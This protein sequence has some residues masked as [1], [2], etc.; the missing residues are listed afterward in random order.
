MDSNL[1]VVYVPV[2]ELN[3]SEYNPRK[4][5][6]S[7]T[8]ALRESISRFGLVDPIICN[9]A[10]ERKN[11]VIGGHFRLKVAKD[12]KLK[13]VPVVYV[14]IADIERE[15]ELNV[16]LNKNLGEFD[17]ELLKGFGEDFLVDVGFTSEEMDDIFAIEPTPEHFDLKAELHKLKIDK[18]EAQKGDIYEIDG[19]RLMVG[20]STI[21]A[22]MLKLMNGAQTDFCFTDPPYI[23]DLSLIH[24]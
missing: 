4:W 1:K 9:S 12:L 6:E 16:R 23:L 11:I 18:I 14:N 19:S 24:I 2:T 10:P 13:E 20:D 21:E 7:Q 22:D 5:S 17:F 3:P 15:K 8:E